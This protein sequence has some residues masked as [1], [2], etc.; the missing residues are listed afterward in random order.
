MKF[1]IHFFLFCIYFNFVKCDSAEFSLSLVRTGAS[2]NGDQIYVS[3]DTL[4]INFEDNSSGTEFKGVVTDLG[5]IK[6]A[7]GSYIYIDENKNL[8][9]TTDSNEATTNFSVR[10]G[11]LAY[12]NDAS[13]YVL[14]V[15]DS[16]VFKVGY[17]TDSSFDSVLAKCSDSNGNTISSFEP[18]PASVQVII[19]TATNSAVAPNVYVTVS[20]STT[21]VTS[22]IMSSINSMTSVSGSSSKSAEFSMMTIRSGSQFQYNGVYINSTDNTLRVSAS[23]AAAGRELTQFSGHITG[24][25]YIRCFNGGYMSV[26]NDKTLK[27]TDETNSVIVG[28]SVSGGHLQYNSEDSFFANT[29]GTANY[30]K[31]GYADGSENLGLVI[32][33]VDTS[34][35]VIADFSGSDSSKGTS[36]QM[37]STEAVSTHTNPKSSAS[38]SSAGIKTPSVTSSFALPTAILID[39]SFL[40]NEPFTN[41]SFGSKSPSLSPSMKPSTSVTSTTSVGRSTLVTS[42]TRQSSSPTPVSSRTASNDAIP[43]VASLRIMAQIIPFAVANLL[44]L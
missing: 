11:Y 15:D 31:L 3:D 7:D 19:S 30:L 34:G 36:R 35:V 1:S 29:T 23:S 16:Y 38:V 42:S 39:T 41:G 32:R 10:S 24:E 9:T 21:S 18:N 33:A 43:S 37:S 4:V 17:T 27:C 13:F 28:F 6:L 5:Y 26:G 14:P 40:A 25:G 8:R 12:N 2:Y 22:A 44:F 20:G